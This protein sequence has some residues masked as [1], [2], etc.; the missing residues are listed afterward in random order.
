MTMDTRVKHDHTSPLSLAFIQHSRACAVIF[1]VMFV[2]SSF[3]HSVF[4]L[5]LG[6]YNILFLN[7]SIELILVFGP[8]NIRMWVVFYSTS[9]TE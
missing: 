2:L 1:T 4:V 6:T 8:I 7:C 9:V 3:G 5:L